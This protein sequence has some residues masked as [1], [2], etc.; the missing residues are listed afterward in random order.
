[1]SVK[2]K[3]TCFLCCLLSAVAAMAYELHDTVP[4]LQ[5]GDS[6]A[7]RP[8]TLMFSFRSG[9]GV[10]F[11]DYKQNAQ[12]LDA[13]AD[14]LVASLPQIEAGQLKVRVLGY[15]TS[16]SDWRES[17]ALAK[18]RSNQVKSYFI[19]NSGMKEDYFYTTNRVRLYKG[20]SDVVLIACIPQVPATPIEPPIQVTEQTP[21]EQQGNES[22]SA[23]EQEENKEESKVEEHPQN[24]L[25]VEK[26]EY[27]PDAS[28]Q[29][30][31][32][33]KSESSKEETE[34]ESSKES[35]KSETE[36][37][38]QPEQAGQ[39]GQT[40]DPAKRRQETPTH[41]DN[42]IDEC[43]DSYRPDS[44]S[45]LNR[46]DS[47]G[48]TLVA[49]SV[50]GDGQSEIQ[51]REK[52]H[53][54]SSDMWLP[55]G[56]EVPYYNWA[57]KTNAL[58]LAATVANLGVEYC[59]GRHYSI[60]VPVMYSPYTVARNYRMRFLAVQPEFRYWLKLPTKGHFFGFHLNIGACNVSVDKYNRYQ[61]PNGFYGV[62]IS[63][64]YVLPFSKHWAGEFT[65]GVG[66]VYA[67]YE[68]FYNIHNGACYEK[69]KTFHYVGPTK[70]GVNIV[71]RF[72]KERR[73][74]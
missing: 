25:P 1:M 40:E 9:S 60:D 39:S 33:E 16:F 48:T 45:C 69:N 3:L 46:V 59:F 61:T 70:L 10:F 73:G 15:C 74:K 53:N 27:S 57:V 5:L 42:R 55:V 49:D 36:Q 26:E 11:R 54:G 4:A 17:L 63:Y 32:D 8:D 24:R 58:Y 41:K 65:V 35:T 13:F 20:K 62:G 22:S 14:F 50:A 68:T 28:K 19:T 18:R 2:R 56:I 67:Q 29:P 44:L 38:A 23:A 66:Y 21:S 71:Y 47:I 6:V 12:N 52:K 51:R 7:Y 43:D 34:S 30:Q 72:G 37:P 64:G 31:K